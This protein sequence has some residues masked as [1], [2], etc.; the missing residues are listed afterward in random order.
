MFTQKIILFVVL[1]II[2]GGCGSGEETSTSAKGGNVSIS[3]KDL[4]QGTTEVKK[5]SDYYGT[6][7]FTARPL[8]GS[9]KG[10][11]FKTYEVELNLGAFGEGF[12][13]NII[14]ASIEEDNIFSDFQKL[15]QN[16][17]YVF[18]FDY[19]HRLNPEI[20]DTH[21]HIRSWEPLKTSASVE[22]KGVQTHREKTGPYSEGVR[23]G[24]VVQVERWGYWDIDCSVTILMGGIK[25]SRLKKTSSEN[26]IEMNTYS[27]ETCS[28]AEKALKAGVD[29]SFL[30]SEDYIE[31]WDK[32]DRILHVITILPPEALSSL[33]AGKTKEDEAA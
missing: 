24:R 8:K 15:D 14:Q 3:S 4:V 25:M 1:M 5:S 19:P 31:I 27:E 13:G 6:G 2:A 26:S 16:N 33:T 12:V 30:Y 11:V 28:F 10:F 18:K 20:E 7:Y 21:I 9:E 32:F 17:L 22:P 29:V 23:Q